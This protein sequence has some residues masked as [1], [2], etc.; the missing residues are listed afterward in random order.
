MGRIRIHS[1]LSTQRAEYRTGQKC[2]LK[3]RWSEGKSF[4]LS[5]CVYMYVNEYMLVWHL[6]D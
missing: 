5:V 1:S 6:I 4:S 2:L 3:I